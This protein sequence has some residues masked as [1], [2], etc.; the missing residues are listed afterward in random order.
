M[1]PS[2]SQNGPWKSISIKFISKLP[3]SQNNDVI[4]VVLDQFS[5]MVQFIYTLPSLNKSHEHTSTL[6]GLLYWCSSRKS[7]QWPMPSI[8]CRI[9][10]ICFFELSQ[11]LRSYPL[12]HLTEPHLR[13]EFTLF[14]SYQLV[15]WVDWF[16]GRILV[17]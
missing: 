17:Q 16:H 8:H 6:W 11:M 13:E 1:E 12:N 9:L 2:I 3:W 15:E 4:L 14:F 5:K 7:Y 10:E